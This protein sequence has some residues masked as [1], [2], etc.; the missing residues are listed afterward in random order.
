MTREELEQKT[1]DVISPENYYDVRNDIG[2][3]SDAYLRGLIA[4]DG[5]YDAEWTYF[6]SFVL[7]E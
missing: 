5:S 2:T 7:G 3:M 6:E 4:C 1:L